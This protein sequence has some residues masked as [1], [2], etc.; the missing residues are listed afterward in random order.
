MSNPNYISVYILKNFLG[1]KFKLLVKN[2]FNIS[3]FVTIIKI[4]TW[5]TGAYDNIEGWW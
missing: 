4:I 1:H 5:E 3:F 2:Y